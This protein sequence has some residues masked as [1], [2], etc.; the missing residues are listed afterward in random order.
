MKYFSYKQYILKDL[1][2]YKEKT[3]LSVGLCLPIYNEATTIAKTIRTVKKCGNLIDK[4]VAIE[5]KPKNPKSN[6]IITGLYL[7]GVD[8]FDKIKTLKPSPRGELEITDINNLY[9]KEGRLSFGHVTGFWSDAGT[10]SSLF[11]SAEWAARE[12]R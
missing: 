6:Y 9:L 1:I 11:K 12:S 3:K 4:I 7:Y 10:F 2:A 5:E 8:V